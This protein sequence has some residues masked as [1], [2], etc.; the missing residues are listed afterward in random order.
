MTARVEAALAAN[1]FALPATVGAA[2]AAIAFNFPGEA[3][4]A[5]A[6]KAAPTGRMRA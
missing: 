5:I 3:R 4:T 6:A 2:S 1:A